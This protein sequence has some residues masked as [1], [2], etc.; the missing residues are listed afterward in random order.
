MVVQSDARAIPLPSGVV[1]L[2]I[3]DSPYAV[4]K[5]DPIQRKNAKAIERYQDWDDMTVDEWTAM[6]LASLR[7]VY[8]VSREGATAYVWIAGE[9][10]T[11]LKD[12]C[13]YVGFYWRM[14]F[15]WHLSNPAPKVRVVT[16]QSA[17]QVAGV[18]VKGKKNTFNAING[19][20]CHNHF[21]GPMPTGSG[22]IHPTQKSYELMTKLIMDA[23]HPGDL[24]MDTFCGSG[25]VGEAA[26]NMGR[27]YFCADLDAR[28]AQAALFKCEN[29][30]S[31][32]EESVADLPLFVRE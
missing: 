17:V 4:L 18:V 24:V 31:G 26:K 29:K 15:F 2:T 20:L 13:E 22:R 11:L 16:Y 5:H 23:S 30:V 19:G 6:M 28:W 21:E 27:R 1:D 32:A 7:E 8:R 10:T 14:P 12:I 9:F 3:I 25:V